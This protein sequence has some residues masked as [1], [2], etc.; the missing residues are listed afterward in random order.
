MRR[1]SQLYVP[2]NN[3]R[4]IAKAATLDA[5]SIVF[6][7]EDAVPLEEK[8]TARVSLGSA[9]GKADW[10]SRHLA[11]RINAP[12]TPDGQ[13]DIVTLAAEPRITTLV[14]PKAEAD[15][16]PLAR[17]TGKDL[18]PLIETP[19]GL[20]HIEEVVRSERAIAVSY[21]ASDLAASIG[22]RSGRGNAIR[23]SARSSP[24]P[25]RRTASTQSTRC[26]STSRTW[27]ASGRK[28]STRSGSATSASRSSIRTRSRSRTRC[29]RRARRS[30]G[31][32]PRSS[33]RM[34]RRPGKGAGR[35]GC[36]TGSST[37]CT[38]DWRS[39]PLSGRRPEP[40][41]SLAPAVQLREPEGRF[42]AEGEVAARLL[43]LPEVRP[44]VVPEAGMGAAVDD[45][46]RPLPY[47]EPAEVRD[48]LLRHEDVDV[49]AGD[50]RA[51]HDGDDPREPVPRRRRG[52]RDDDEPRRA[53][54]VLRT[55]NAV[56][57]VPADVRC[58]RA[59]EHVDLDRLLHRDDVQ[60]GDHLEAVR[61][62]VRPQ[63]DVLEDGIDPLDEILRHVAVSGKPVHRGRADP[64][65]PLPEHGRPTRGDPL[66]PDIRAADRQ[67]VHQRGGEA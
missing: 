39:G 17:A 26:S 9:L 64:A 27:T 11:V 65:H 58:V 44:Q 53:G 51:R 43:R 8:V 57:R 55:A 25:P 42:E 30:S 4:M 59:S 54:E 67:G 23:M 52:H 33:Q 66:R 46:L 50:V 31:G 7:L 3:P 6:D 14:I 41:W 18:I 19:T 5:D 48:P 34:R 49:L 21:G 29:S 15:L 62:L 60:A 12:G 61:H 35:S 47:G 40:S 63:D 16:S 1:R 22:A 32:R 2:A 56:V 36:G 28:P 37:R 45:R 10:G 38:T 13:A 20:L 24:S